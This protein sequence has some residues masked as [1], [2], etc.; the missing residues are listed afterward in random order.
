M[1]IFL[2][3]GQHFQNSYIPTLSTLQA[4]FH[5][6]YT[7]SS[8]YSHNNTHISIQKK[9][10]CFKCLPTISLLNNTKHV[11]INYNETNLE[12]DAKIA[13]TIRHKRYKLSIYHE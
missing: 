3:A 12:N 7:I 6:Q 2:K 11:T 8:Y 9:N 10:L 1:N 13:L 4:L 5:C